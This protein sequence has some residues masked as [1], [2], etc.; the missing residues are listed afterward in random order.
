MEQPVS[1]VLAFLILFRYIIT[2]GAC[3]CYTVFLQKY[4]FFGLDIAGYKCRVV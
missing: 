3:P 2:Y 4:S 1:M